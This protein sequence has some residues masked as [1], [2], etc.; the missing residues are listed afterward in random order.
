MARHLSPDSRPSFPPLALCAAF[1]GAST[2]AHA[3]PVITI[4]AR[5]RVV[6]TAVAGGAIAVA[7]HTIATDVRDGVDALQFDGATLA[8]PAPPDSAQDAPTPPAA[9][10]ADDGEPATGA[11]L[12]KD[13]GIGGRYGVVAAPRTSAGQSTARAIGVAP[14]TAAPKHAVP[15]VA[16]PKAGMAPATAPAL[17]APVTPPAPVA[18]PAPAP[19]PPAAAVGG[20]ARPVVGRVTSGFGQRGGSFHA[21]LDIANVIGTPIHAVAAGQVIS[22][23][24]ASGFG[25][26]V[27]VRHNDGTITVY[28][29][30]NRFFVSV[31]Q[32]VAAGAVIAEVGNRGQST[33]PHLHLEVQLPNGTKVDPRGWLAARGVGV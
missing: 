10:P 22:A 1:V 23:G 31:G 11:G 6:F 2:G 16:A 5:A 26:W 7:A 18:K 17:P 15:N 29:H 32:R 3:V 13:S 24:A 12:V 20:F 19:K 30:V 4:G 28:G 8:D 25:L 9:P 33:G 21:G 27:R 14:K